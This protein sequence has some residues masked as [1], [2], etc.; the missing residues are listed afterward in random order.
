VAIT[1]YAF[2]RFIGDDYGLERIADR[3]MHYVTPL[4]F[5][6]DWVAFVP[7]GRLPWTMVATSLLLP[8]AYA[9]WVI[10]H[11]VIANWYPYPF[12]DIR[13]LG[14]QQGMEHMA[15]FLGV[16]VAITLTLLAI[17]RVMGSV[18]RSQTQGDPPAGA[19]RRSRCPDFLLGVL[20]RIVNMDATNEDGRRRDSVAS[21]GTSLPQARRTPART[22]SESSFASDWN[23]PCV[24]MFLGRP[25]RRPGNLQWAKQSLSFLCAA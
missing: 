24:R 17:D 15:G 1:Y 11:G 4:L 13:S 8:L 10:V 5:L 20:A 22:R 7:K 16:F 21:A 25:V 2:L 23:Q 6:I 3:L 12:V 14:Y 19:L 18:Q 9:V